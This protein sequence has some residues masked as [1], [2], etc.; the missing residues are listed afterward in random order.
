MNHRYPF[1]MF[2]AVTL[3][4]TVDSLAENWPQFRGPESNSQS[5]AINLP[6]KWNSDSVAWR[7]ELPGEGHSS[8][9]TWDNRIFVTTSEKQ[10]DSVTRR[11]VCVNAK[12]GAIFWQR[13]V[14]TGPAESVHAMN[15]YATSTPATDGERVYAFFG[16]GGFH[17]LDMQ[18]KVLWS[19]ELGKFPGPFGTGSSPLI[20]GDLVI[21]SCDSGD[22]SLSFI[23]AYNRLTGEELWR[24]SRNIKPISRFK[25]SK[26]G[27]ASPIL[28]TDGNQ[29]QIVINGQFGG[30]AYDLKTG[31][32]LWHCW[33]TSTQGRG[34][35]SCLAGKGVIYVPNERPEGGTTYAIKP[36][37]RGDATNVKDDLAWKTPRLNGRVLASPVKVGETLFLVAMNGVGIR[38]DTQTGKMASPMRLGGN[39]SAT[40]LVAKELV[41]VLEE[42]GLTKVFRFNDE[43][44]MVA[45]NKSL[46]SEHEEV[47]RASIA[48]GDGQLFIRSTRALYCVGGKN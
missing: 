4:I 1:A 11:V 19:K 36:T 34:T 26:G 40:P 23:A 47:F 29:Q 13:D 21:Q 39:Y 24:T 6:V 27:W 31:K 20:V 46:K 8:P 17:C 30:W 16:R 48:P 3:C 5:Q 41:Y 44:E 45:E 35:P 14:H 2:L 33:D 38:F 15:S 7:T 9:I 37:A 25:G 10:G 42:S 43:P 12:D 28:F 18:G 32:E 22:T